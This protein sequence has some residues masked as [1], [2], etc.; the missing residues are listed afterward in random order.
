MFKLKY[1]GE[2]PEIKIGNK[3]FKRGKDYEVDDG[4]KEKIKGIEGF[5]EKTKV[6]KS[7]SKDKETK[8]NKEDN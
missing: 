2:Y 6:K 1:E 5:E 3:F 4:F 7:K 8:D